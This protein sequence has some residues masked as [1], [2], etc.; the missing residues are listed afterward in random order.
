MDILI[1]TID[2]LGRRVLLDQSAFEH[3]I[4]A[5]HPEMQSALMAIKQTIEMPRAIYRS[6]DDQTRDLFL[7]FQGWWVTVVSDFRHGEYGVIITA[8]GQRTE[9]SLAKKGKQI[10]P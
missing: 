3:H 1:D 2:P 4:V 5:H 8:W 10:W 7:G 6:Q 9:P